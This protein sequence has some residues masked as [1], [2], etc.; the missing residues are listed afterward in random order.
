VKLAG[1]EIY[2]LDGQRVTGF[3][4]VEEEQVGLTAV[5]RFFF[6]FLLLEDALNTASR[7]GHYE[8]AKEL[9]GKKVVVAR[10]GRLITGQNP[11]S[12]TGV[13][14]AIYEFMMPFLGR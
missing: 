14:R 7:G 3:S 12:T 10:G 1:G 8:K 9:W 6:F 5:M 2:L 11:A 13:G 4:D